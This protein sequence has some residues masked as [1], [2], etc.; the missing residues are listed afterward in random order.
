MSE[1]IQIAIGVTILIAYHIYQ[2]IKITDG[3]KWF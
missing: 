1:L 2:A 3:K